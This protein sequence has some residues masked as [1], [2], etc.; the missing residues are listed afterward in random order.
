M[1]H[2]VT[3]HFGT[4]AWFEIQRRHLE[5]YT[6][7]PEKVQVHCIVYKTKVPKDFLPT[8]LNYNYILLNNEQ[9][10][11]NEHYLII[12][13][14]FDK[15]VKP[16]IKDEDVVVYMDSDAF[17][18][19]YWDSKIESYMKTSH[20][21]AVYRYEDRGPMQPNRY[22]PYP[23]LCFYAFKKADREKYGFRHEIP[24]GYPCPGFTIC[25]VIREKNLVVKELKRT[26]KYNNHNTMFGVYDD[27]IYHQSSGSRAKVGRPYQTMGAQPDTRPMCYEGI[28][29]YYRGNVEEHVPGFVETEAGALNLKIFDAVFDAINNDVDCNFLRRYYLGKA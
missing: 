14:C 29:F 5:K 25:D 9:D 20:I 15:F 22:Y 1:I 17:P 28:D 7:N 6:E 16:N 24:P 3:Q 26:N 18:I 19:D 13:S 12:E 2:I 23:H 21:C 8:K 27:F 11:Q 4:D 10:V